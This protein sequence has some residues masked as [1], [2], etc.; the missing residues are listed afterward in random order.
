MGVVIGLL[1]LAGVLMLIFVVRAHDGGFLR[2]GSLKVMS[3]RRRPTDGGSSPSGGADSPVSGSGDR[4]TSPLLNGN[5]A[6]LLVQQASAGGSSV[7]T[8][9][10]W[11]TR[12]ST[13]SCAGSVGVGA[14]DPIEQMSVV[15][16]ESP[17]A[18]SVSRAQHL[19]H[20][21]SG[22]PGLVARQS[23]STAADTP[24]SSTTGCHR[25]TDSFGS[26]T[27]FGSKGS[28]GGSKK[29]L[30]ALAAAGAAAQ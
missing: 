30:L 12:G 13:S 29:D 9:S 21:G 28:A 23:S 7:L 14:N 24:S 17:F 6:R 5:G 18:V 8:T 22:G 4:F 16:E 3:L 1:L 25:A 19:Q 27:L 10:S 15:N 20:A 26:G 2:L 11:A